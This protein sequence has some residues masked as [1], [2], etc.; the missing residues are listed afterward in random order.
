MNFT[1][2]F[3]LSCPLLPW[4]TLH[5]TSQALNKPS[6]FNLQQMGGLSTERSPSRAESHNLPVEKKS[7]HIKLLVEFNSIII[8]SCTLRRMKFVNTSVYFL[9][10]KKEKL[11]LCR[12]EMT[13]TWRLKL[14]PQKPYIK[15]WARQ[16]T[17]SSQHCMDKKISG[18]HGVYCPVSLAYLEGQDN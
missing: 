15:M 4:D 9:L 7:L 3:K 18:I 11:N 8:S 1:N 5:P 14:E 10:L 12:V 13:Q 2:N 16:R 6:H 17:L